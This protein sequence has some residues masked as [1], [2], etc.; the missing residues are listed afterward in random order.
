MS[1]ASEFQ[2]SHGQEAVRGQPGELQETVRQT[3]VEGKQDGL[4]FNRTTTKRA[5]T[6]F[7]SFFFFLFSNRQLSFRIVALCNHLTRI[8]K[9]GHKLPE[10]GVRTGTL[11]TFRKVAGSY[12]C[13]DRMRA[14]YKS[15]ERMEMSLLRAEN[16]RKQ[17]D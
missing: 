3:Q 14:R 15:A 13:T 11:F 9:K 7:I 6:H 16:R 5:G 1:A 10:D 8:M 4:F 12:F 2:T 17:P